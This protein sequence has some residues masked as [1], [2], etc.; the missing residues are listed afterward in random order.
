M[1]QGYFKC[2]NLVKYKG[3]PTDIV[4]RSSWE[5]KMMVYLDN[6]PDVIQWS[7]EE[8]RIPYRCITDGRAH[9]Y[10]PDMWMKKS[11]GE[12]LLLEV[13][14]FIQTQPPRE[15]KK[16]NRRYL[17]EVLTYGKNISK[18]KAAEAYCKARGWVFKLM[19]EHELGIPVD[20]RG[21]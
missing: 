12:C 16:K 3:N 1:I 17:K 13:K 15:P 20:K 2:R 4:Y 10:F 19:T 5:L 21:R 18:W 7:S 11:N 6:H 9:T 14:P 8:I